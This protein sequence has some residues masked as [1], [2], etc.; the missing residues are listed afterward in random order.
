MGSGRTGNQKQV[1]VACSEPLCLEWWHEQNQ[2]L[3]GYCGGDPD[4]GDHGCGRPYCEKHLYLY[5]Y[6]GD[7]DD[8]Y[9]LPEPMCG[10]CIEA[11][12]E[13]TEPE[14]E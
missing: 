13:P 7:G 11:Y 9:E 8:L 4:G 6:E 10:L 12:L 5:L 1:V 14:V 3:P 2:E